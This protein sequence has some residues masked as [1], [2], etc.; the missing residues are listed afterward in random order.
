MASANLDIRIEAK[1]AFSATFDSL[2]NSLGQVNTATK[3]TG[4]GFGG[5]V[6]GLGRIGLAAEGVKAIFS[7]IV[8]VFG[9]PVKAASDLN[10]S[11][12]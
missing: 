4:A 10:E 1:D 12:G 8:S 11:M 3:A 5:L 7:G 9:A 6:E 2:H